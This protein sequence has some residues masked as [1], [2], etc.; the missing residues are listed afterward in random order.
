MKILQRLGASRDQSL[1]LS[2]LRNGDAYN[3]REIIERLN[4]RHRRIKAAI[5]AMMGY[6]WIGQYEVAVKGRNRPHKYYYLKV[7]MAEIILHYERQTAE[8]ATYIVKSATKLR[9][10]QYP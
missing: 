7:D 4:I 1:V 6:G 9:E 5:D 2:I 8:E 10:L 3:A